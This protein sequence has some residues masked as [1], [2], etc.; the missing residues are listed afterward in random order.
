MLIQI[1]DKQRHAVSVVKTALL[2][3]GISE[4]SVCIQ[5]NSSSSQRETEENYSVFVSSPNRANIEPFYATG[6]TL[7][8]AVKN[9]ISSIKTVNKAEFIGLSAQTLLMP[10]GY[11]SA[12]TEDTPF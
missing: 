12:V 10:F 8:E 4:R 11:N 5:I 2:S 3:V 6:K 1:V 7:A 9:A